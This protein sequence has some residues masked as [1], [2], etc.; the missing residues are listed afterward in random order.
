LNRQRCT[1][2]RCPGGGCLPAFASPHPR[3]GSR[4]EVFPGP[5]LV[6][7]EGHP[8]GRPSHCDEGAT[9]LRLLKFKVNLVIEPPLSVGFPEWLVNQ[10]RQWER[11]GGT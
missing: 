7:L 3:F 10:L 2:A 5:R 4:Y 8:L 1:L 9:P 6:D 11:F